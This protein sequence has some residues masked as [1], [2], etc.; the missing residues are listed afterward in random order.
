MKNL[1]KLASLT[2]FCVYLGNSDNAITRSPYL[3]LSIVSTSSLSV[4]T[5]KTAV[6]FFSISSS[7]QNRFCTRFI[8]SEADIDLSRYAISML[9]P[10]TYFCRNITRYLLIVA[11]SSL[12]GVKT[13]RKH[14]EYHLLRIRLNEDD[15]EDCTIDDKRLEFRREEKS[16]E[17]SPPR[18]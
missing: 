18:E 3:F 1:L 12:L 2:C 10:I 16:L 4:I 8:A 5:N 11:C 13:L 17:N 14:V 6:S 7:I 15:V 9:T